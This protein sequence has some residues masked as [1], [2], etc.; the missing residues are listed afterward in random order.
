MIRL[1]NNN[2][3]TFV[4]VMLSILET[5]ERNDE[6]AVSRFEQIEKSRTK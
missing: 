2:L 1:G 6:V 4:P 5:S 3:D